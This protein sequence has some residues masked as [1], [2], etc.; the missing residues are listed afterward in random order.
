MALVQLLAV[1][2]IPVARIILCCVVFVFVCVF[3]FG[4]RC[5]G[6]VAR[7]IPASCASTTHSSS[8]HSLCLAAKQNP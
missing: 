7:I 2:G 5:D 1:E 3:V 4:L 6:P 8:P